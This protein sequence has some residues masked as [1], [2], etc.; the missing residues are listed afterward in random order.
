MGNKFIG[1][2]AIWIGSKVLLEHKYAELKFAQKPIFLCLRFFN[3][4]E[5]LVLC[6]IS[7]FSQC[8]TNMESVVCFNALMFIPYIGF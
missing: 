1:S 5:N 4:P 8:P 7:V 6:F 3:E 2:S